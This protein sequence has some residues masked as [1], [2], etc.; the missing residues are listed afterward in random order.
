MACLRESGEFYESE[1]EDFNFYGHRLLVAV[2]AISIQAGTLP[3]KHPS[4][5]VSVAL[6]ID[7]N[8]CTN[9]GV[10]QG[11]FANDR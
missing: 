4:Q 9:T 10:L 7:S 5:I 1:S 8:D 3:V 2:G 6:E 11:F